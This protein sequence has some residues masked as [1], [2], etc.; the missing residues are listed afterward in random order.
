VRRRQDEHATR[1]AAERFA[2]RKL[3]FIGVVLHDGEL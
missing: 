3:T 2:D 1:N